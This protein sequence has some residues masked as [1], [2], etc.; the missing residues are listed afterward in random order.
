MKINVLAGVEI[1]GRPVVQDHHFLGKDDHVLTDGS[2]SDNLIFAF[3]I[4]LYQE[5]PLS[6]GR[7]YHVFTRW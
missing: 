4:G 3:I 1:R 2:L 5:G 7:D 6:F